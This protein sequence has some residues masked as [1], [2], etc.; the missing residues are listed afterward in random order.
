MVMGSSDA[1]KVL[2]DWMRVGVRDG[3]DEIV[4]ILLEDVPEDD[5][6]FIK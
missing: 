2:R 3:R 5:A 1:R 6:M 4:W